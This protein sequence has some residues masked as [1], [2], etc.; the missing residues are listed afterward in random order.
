[1]TLVVV[2][3]ELTVKRPN[4][5]AGGRETALRCAR[6]I[7]G[8]KDNGAMATMSTSTLTN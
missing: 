6:V 7:P 3:Q 5:K 8:T 1:M 4:L 2:Q